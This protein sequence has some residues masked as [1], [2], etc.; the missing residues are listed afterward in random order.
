MRVFGRLRGSGVRVGLGFFILL[1]FVFMGSVLVFAGTLLVLGVNSGAIKF[2]NDNF[3]VKI[4][5]MTLGFF[6]VFLGAHIA[7]AGTD[8][9]VTYI[10]GR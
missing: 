7:I 9:L 10:K 5:L 2:G 1:L 4:I 8:S 3:Y 6:L